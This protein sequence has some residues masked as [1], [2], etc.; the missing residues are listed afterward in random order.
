MGKKNYMDKV[1]CMLGVELDKDFKVHHPEGCSI[2]RLTYDGI[3]FMMHLGAL[4]ENAP[5]ICLEQ[6]IKGNYEIVIK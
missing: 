5:A 6:L 1:A 2:V 3:V 4:K